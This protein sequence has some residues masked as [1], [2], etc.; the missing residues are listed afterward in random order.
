MFKKIKR[1]LYRSIENRE[2]SYK[3][4]KEII[5]LDKTTILLDVRSRQEYKEGH[6]AN[7]LNIP[8]FDLE[9]QIVQSKLPDKNKTII[10][11]CVSGYRSRKAKEI[12]EEMGY[13]KVYNLK[14]G[15]DGI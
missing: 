12:L 8:L 4:L 5:K 1:V 13:Q 7:A 6:L 11:Y 2:I 15:L 9:K 10:I 3:K 14:N